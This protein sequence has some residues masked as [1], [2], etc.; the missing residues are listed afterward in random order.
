MQISRRSC[1]PNADPMAMRMFD[2]KPAGGGLYQLVVEISSLSHTSI[3]K[4]G[5]FPFRP[6]WYTY[7]GSAKNGVSAR[8]CRHLRRTSKL[9]W[10]IDYLLHSGNAV[11]WRFVPFG[12]KTEC[13]L[14]D[15]T[16]ELPGA[17]RFPPRFG[18]SDCRCKGHLVWTP[19]PP[20]WAETQ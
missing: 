11:A 15:E 7:T 20:E 17:E 3:G 4:L 8:L 2:E 14:A 9:H 6:G 5:A 19:H 12:S 13:S 10:H 1:P 16:A 18:A